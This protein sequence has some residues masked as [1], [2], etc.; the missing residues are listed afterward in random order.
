MMGA[1]TLAAWRAASSKRVEGDTDSAA[2]STSA[3]R[4]P[5]NALIL[6]A[7]SGPASA[8]S[9]PIAPVLVLAARSGRIAFR[10]CL[11]SVAVL[12]RGEVIGSPAIHAGQRFLHAD[13]LPAHRVDGR[14][15]AR[16]AIAMAVSMPFRVPAV[17]RPMA[18]HA[19]P[20]AAAP[21][22]RNVSAN[23]PRRAQIL[24]CD[25]HGVTLN[26]P[27]RGEEP[28]ERSGHH[29]AGRGAARAGRI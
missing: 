28:D 13:G 17:V 16:G 27:D 2:A 15:E 1:H 18:A 14:L 22:P 23:T 19:A 6:P 11:E 5:G 7:C 12:A 25:S 9:M 26:R 24:H 10:R 21:I 8:A 20:H 3:G 4:A 29:H